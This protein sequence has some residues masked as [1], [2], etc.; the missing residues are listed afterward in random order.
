MLQF[1]I[2]LL[3]VTGNPPPDQ[4]YIYAVKD[5]CIDPRGSFPDDSLMRIR[6]DFV[7]YLESRIFVMTLS[8]GIENF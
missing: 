3:F 5:W 8:F 2:W 4:F 1:V 7:G 6:K